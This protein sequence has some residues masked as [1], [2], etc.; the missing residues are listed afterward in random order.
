MESHRYRECLYEHLLLSLFEH[1]DPKCHSRSEFEA[2]L[3]HNDAAHCHM[4]LGE[5]HCYHVCGTGSLKA[6]H[7]NF[8]NVW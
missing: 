8:Q 6:H 5:I 4:Q 2:A 7:D 3:Q 1:H